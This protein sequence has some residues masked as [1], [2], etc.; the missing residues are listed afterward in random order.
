VSNL[1]E[2]LVGRTSELSSLDLALTELERNGPSAVA[3]V[4]ELAW[5]LILTGIASVIVRSAAS[6]STSVAVAVNAVTRNTAAAIGAQVAFAIIA[7][8]DVAGTFPVESAYTWVFG[9]GGLGAALLLLASALMPGRTL[10]P[11]AERREP[12]LSSAG[13][14]GKLLDPA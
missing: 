14:T 8:A 2:T 6:D 9:M 7:G 3:L 12:G 10:L 5:G 1:S 13:R 4:G 11:A